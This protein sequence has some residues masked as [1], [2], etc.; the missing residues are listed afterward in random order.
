MTDIFDDSQ[1]ENLDLVS[2]ETEHTENDLHQ[3]LEEVIAPKQDEQVSKA[4]KNGYLTED[5]YLAKHGSLEGFKSAE[6]FNKYGEA[7]GEVSEVIKG[8]QKQVEESRKQTEVLVNYQQ[9]T[10]ERAYQRAR[11]DLEAQLQQARNLGDVESVEHL[12]KEKS[13]LEFHESQNNHAKL[14]QQRLRVEQDFRENNKHWFGI[15]QEMTQRAVQLDLMIRE[16]AV[17]NNIPLTYESLAKQVEAYLRAEFPDTMIVKATQGPSISASRSNMNKGSN[18][19]AILN[20]DDKTFNSLSNDHKLMYQ[21][22]K[23]IYE[24]GSGK[25]YTKKDFINK[26]KT[27]GEI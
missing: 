27:D 4:K 15:N 26:L 1:D 11:Q 8:L 3:D 14:E 10:E 19:S 12:V 22:V 18:G 6:Q 9:R 17:K 2:S 21:A 25:E 5:E 16:E 7:W 23:R 24:S 20:S 13:K